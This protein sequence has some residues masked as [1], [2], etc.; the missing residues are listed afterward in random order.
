V[1][2]FFLGEVLTTFFVGF[3]DH[4]WRLVN[5]LFRVALPVFPLD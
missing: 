5:G 3:S 4:L 1:F 2:S